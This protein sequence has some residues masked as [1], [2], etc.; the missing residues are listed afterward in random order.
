MKRHALALI[1]AVA[2]AATAPAANY[3]WLGL[4]GTVDWMN[5]ASWYNLDTGTTDVVPAAGDLAIVGYPG[6]GGLYP[7]P[8]ITTVPYD[9]AAPLELLGVDW[10]E[11]AEANPVLTIQGGALEVNQTWMNYTG[12]ETATINITAGGYMRSLGFVQMANT[13]GGTSQI[14]IDSG[15]LYTP[16]L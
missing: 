9:V 13:V 7:W 10:W 11:Q 4:S 6:F 1:A 5:G 3:S 8:V 16:N 2:T 14:N 15:F 12:T